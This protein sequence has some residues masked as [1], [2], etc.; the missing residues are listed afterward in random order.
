M[1]LLLIQ[2]PIL[3]LLA[4]FYV[5]THYV[6]TKF[7]RLIELAGLKSREEIEQK[8]FYKWNRYFQRIRS[9]HGFGYFVLATI[10][11]W[12]SVDSF[13]PESLLDDEEWPEEVGED[14]SSTE[15]HSTH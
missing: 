5:R 1:T 6:G 12:R 4:W 3:F 2:L 15:Q 13:Y 7:K 9:Y 11:I 10:C 8:Q 14:G